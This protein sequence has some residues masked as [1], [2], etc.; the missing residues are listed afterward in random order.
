MTVELDYSVVNNSNCSQSDFETLIRV[1]TN[2]NRYQV[3][4]TDKRILYSDFVNNSS[5]D[6]K[7]LMNIIYTASINVSDDSDNIVKDQ[8]TELKAK[9]FDVNEAITYFSTPL[10]IVLEN[11]DNDSYLVSAIF[12]YFASNTCF[13]EKLQKK[14][15]KFSGNGGCSSIDDVINRELRSNGYKPKMLRFYVILDSDKHYKTQRVTKYDKLKP[16]LKE[17]NIKYH[18]WEKRSAENYLPTEAFE[19]FR[20]KTTEKWIN[21][22]SHLTDDQKDFIDISGG[23]SKDSGKGADKSVPNRNLLKSINSE[24]ADFIK[25]VSDT[26]FNILWK[27]LE[28]KDFKSEFP[29]AF[30]SRYVYKETLEKRIRQQ[31][32][33][34][35]FY[36]IVN[37]I[38]GLL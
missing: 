18:I 25:D 20:N 1:L 13:E 2:Q 29:K 28:I 23:Y 8:A 16:I 26:N 17:N 36:C 6:M 15:I 30:E 14:W 4:L 11:C 9:E 31:S 33:P 38:E 22:Y 3:V 24:E 5:A 32:N 27:G 10:E 19:S 21:A 12:K 37:E 34:D 35:E 7:E